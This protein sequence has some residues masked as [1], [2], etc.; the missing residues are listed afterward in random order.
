M[1]KNTK[2]VL[3]IAALAGLAWFFFK[4]SRVI[5]LL[6]ISLLLVYALY[7]ITEYLEKKRKVPHLVSVIVTFVCFLL[8]ILTFIGLIIPVMQSESQGILQDMPQYINQTQFYIEQATEYLA[9]FRVP[10]EVVDS[11][12]NLPSELLPAFEE[13]ASFSVSLISS[14]FDLF[15]VLLIVFYLL[16]D[17]NNIRE[18]IIKLLPRQHE[19]SGRDIIEIIDSNLGNYILGD[20]VR[21]AIVGILTGVALFIAGMPYSFLLG[22]VAGVL[23]IILYIGPILAAIPALILSFSPQAPSLLIV[24]AIYVLVQSIDGLLFSPL[25]LGRAV[26]IKPITIIVALII[27]QELAGVLGMIISTPIAGII[28]SLI[29]YYS[30][31]KEVMAETAIRK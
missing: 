10:P 18:T 15:F 5:E 24:A 31:Q 4:A 17:F 13:V 21:C 29:E 9:A 16:Y 25:L 1:S 12:L 11:L 22:V 7:P 20:I 3:L 14:F 6:V 8:V 26:K 30:S 27:G 28:R 23:N 19:K 2:T